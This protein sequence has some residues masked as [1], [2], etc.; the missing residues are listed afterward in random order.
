MGDLPRLF[1]SL[2]ALCALF[3]AAGA[4]ARPA[5]PSIT[6]PLVE[7]VVTLPPPPLA[8]AATT[9]RQLSLASTT[10]G[11]LNVR[12][13]ASV[14]YV[15]RLAAVQAR[16]ESQLAARV[17][18]ARI[19]WRYRVV[20]DGIAVTVPRSQ[21][22]RLQG[23]DGATLWPTVTYHAL[24]D[25]SPSLIGAPAI[26][27]PTLAS[28]GAGMKIGIIDDGIDQTHPFF[29]PTGYAYPAGF[30]K[31]QRKYTTPKVIVA[32]AFAPPAIKYR[33]ARVPFDPTSSDHATHVAGIAAGNYGTFATD[34]TGNRVSVSGIA[35]RAY[36]GNYKVLTVPTEHFGLDGNSPEI[37]AAIEAAVKD[38]MDVINLSFGEAEI[39][40]SRD[41]VVHA[42]NAAAD[43]GV[44][45]TIAAGNDFEQAGRGS[46]GSPAT[47][48]KA[49]TAAASTNRRG[50]L[51]D[52]IADFSSSGPTPV[53]LAFKPDVT[54]P[55]DGILSSVPA[56]EGLWDVFDGTSMAAPHVAGAI[57]L[58]RQRH[59]SWT[60]AQVK[61]ALESTG[62]P[63][64][65]QGAVGET[66]ATR[67]G[68]GRIDLIHADQ[69]LIF[70]S[71]T[72]LSLGLVR[73]ATTRNVSFAVTDAGGG[74]GA[75]AVR[76][77]QQTSDPGVIVSAPPTV[78]VPG[79]VPLTFAVGA[80]A[81]ERDLTGFVVLTRGTDVRRVP[82]WLRV[83]APKL[84]RAPHRQLTK[85]GIYHA[86]TSRGASLV[87]EYRYPE[88]GPGV[89][90]IPT[91]LSGPELVY[92]I[93]LRRP[94]TNIG[95]AVVSQAAGVRVQPRLV[96]A[97]DENRL[98]GYTGLPGNINPYQDFGRLEPVV[99]VVRPAAG[100]YDLV[101]DTP[102]GGRP[103]P[104]V[105]R[106]WIADS[107][108]PTVRLVRPTAEMLVVAVRDAG[109]GVDP[110]SLEARVDGQRRPVRWS[111]G[112]ALVT[113]GPLRS[114][115]HTLVFTASDYQEAK[116]MENTGPILPNTRIYRTRFT[117]P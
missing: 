61:S 82:Y 114:G 75:W 55:G 32:R 115:A 57:A 111:G 44:A 59:P 86:D 21:L 16:F 92:R 25:R 87:S 38:G 19:G 7:V 28:T 65:D 90:G 1:L 107:T 2:L 66:A 84:E 101:F 116:N 112:R 94:V 100:T 41:I 46:I 81:D 78:N 117:V 60:V 37:A 109:A 91:K 95:M 10:R 93:V 45:A 96:F 33:N 54:A 103:G 69:P 22:A 5:T 6:D 47:A 9:D 42:V 68:G 49:I 27:G 3:A 15:R 35:P 89:G 31:G 72:G 50:Q 43:A 39:D 98:V 102:D 105:F 13:P 73:R 36:L 62:D 56:K 20:L 79:N 85:A 67:E 53:S 29:S 51:P 64:R 110:G 30:P 34:L 52:V 70:T 4:R 63:V 48:T 58:L 26:W 23:I 40:P 106:Y 80:T 104:F 14:S 108:P 17:P 113:A 88:G 77:L 12:A 99:G 71:P 11:R 97:G 83:E 76:V 8:Q 74:A 18:Q 24:L